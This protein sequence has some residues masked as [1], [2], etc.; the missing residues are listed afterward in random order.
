MPRSMTSAPAARAW[1]ASISALELT[2][3][4]GCGVAPGHEL[5]AGAEDRH[6][7]RAMDRGPGEAAAGQQRELAGAEFGP[8][9]QQAGARGNVAAGGAD[10]VTSGAKR[11]TRAIDGE[12]VAMAG[13]VLLRDHGVGAR[14]DH[15]AGRS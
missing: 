15:G 3:W 4:P 2:T 11:P 1:Q 12:L 7:R 10:E 5:V 14:W 13:A 9:G 6:A 8:G